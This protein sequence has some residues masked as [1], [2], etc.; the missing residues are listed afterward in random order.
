M[1]SKVKKILPVLLILVTILTMSAVSAI[2]DNGTDNTLSLEENNNNTI[3]VSETDIQK[4]ANENSTSQ[5]KLGASSDDSEVV[6]GVTEDYDYS[7]IPSDIKN[8]V[9][10]GGAWK[11]NVKSPSV[12][13]KYQ[14][15]SY[16]KI[17]AKI[18]DGRAVKNTVLTLKIY[19]G[20]SYKYYTVKTN[21]NGVAKFNTKNLKVGT[22]KVYVFTKS[23]DY[24][25]YS[26][27]KIIVKKSSTTTTAK[28]K[29]S[30]Y[31]VTLALKNIA[32]STPKYIK[33]KTGQ[34]LVGFYKSN[35]QGMYFKG[36]HIG[37]L[38]QPGQGDTSN[39]KLLKAKVFFK[40]KA[41]KTISKT[42]TS[43]TSKG[44][45]MKLIKWV[46]GYT[47]VKA[48]VWYKHR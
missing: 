34:K 8:Y 42:Y 14:T 10:T 32:K 43:V 48:T 15:N 22:H 47:P 28:K 6:L 26:A 18:V 3:S 17:T 20:N 19:T 45:N 4:Q 7:S 40:N 21:T 11:T 38:L 31:S 41:G 37:T 16:F 5:G 1:T 25:L 23:N 46:S 13:V 24:D 44:F 30:S 33:L 39:T 9:Y 27:S 36:V 2:D 29:T 35:N 12:T